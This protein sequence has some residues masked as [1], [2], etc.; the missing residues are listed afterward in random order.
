M[1]AIVYRAVNTERGKAYI[2]CTSKSLEKR[3]YQ[4]ELNSRKDKTQIISLAIRKYGAD[5]FKWEVLAVVKDVEEAKRL[6]VELIAKF[7]T[8][9]PH[10]YNMTDG[11]D[12]AFGCKR[13]EATKEKLRAAAIRRGPMPPEQREKISAA[14]KKR[15]ADPDNRARHSAKLK[16]VL[17]A[18]EHKAKVGEA[19]KAR[20]RDPDYRARRKAAHEKAM[21]SPETRAKLS[22][23]HKGRVFTAAHRAALSAACKRRSASAEYRARVSA[24]CR[25][26]AQNRAGRGA[27]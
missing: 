15:F 14:G 21:A 1:P 17:S 8:K 23:A 19:S 24:G 16:V 11:G 3:R 13:S 4:H 9:A 10:G 12:G 18:P 25:R 26:A 27:N 7:D 20:W 5:A 22:A 6:E 2:G